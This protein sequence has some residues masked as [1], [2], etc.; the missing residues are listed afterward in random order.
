MNREITVP[1][2]FTPDTAYYQEIISPIDACDEIG[3]TR[4]HGYELY[5]KGQLYQFLFVLDNRFRNT[6]SRTGNQKKLDKMKIVLK[7]IE[8]HY[9]DRITIAEIA[10]A[11]GFS[12]SHFMRYFKE[13]MGTSFVDYLRDFRLTM[14]SRLLR[15]SD[16]TILHIASETGFDNLSYFN[17]AFKQKYHTTPSRFRRE[18]QNR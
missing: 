5:I 7:Y 3:K 16:N 18:D 14:A 9:P 1:A 2:I 17:R 13:V 15:S 12:E 10:S 4:P 11:V 8:N 6:G